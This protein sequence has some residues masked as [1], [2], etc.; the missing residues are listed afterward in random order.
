MNKIVKLVLYVIVI[1]VPAY[2][3]S[4][5]F[6]LWRHPA[7]RVVIKM[8]KAL[9]DGDM[10]AYAE[11]I[12]PSDQLQPNVLGML[13]A[14]SIGI[15]PVGVDISKLLGIDVKNLDVLSTIYLTDT[16]AL[17]QAEGLV[18]YSYRFYAT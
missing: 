15:G 7:E 14:L 4:Q 5:Y 6:G 3:V 1:V 16:Y 8:Y 12:L 11:I 9:S 17:V 18:N 10:N 13:D 2:F